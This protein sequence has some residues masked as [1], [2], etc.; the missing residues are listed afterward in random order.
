LD[1]LAPS[2]GLIGN[3][4]CKEGE[5]FPSFKTFINFY[6]RNPTI[7]KG[8]VHESLILQVKVGDSLLVSSTLHP[9]QHITGIVTG[10]GSRIVEIPERLRKMPDIK[11]YGREVLIAI[12]AENNFLQKEKVMLN[13]LNENPESSFASFFSLLRKKTSVKDDGIKNTISSKESQQ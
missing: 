2:D 12:P 13:S 7:V 11:T 4:P 5:N 3:I 9:E 1:I 6:E 10:L 8:F